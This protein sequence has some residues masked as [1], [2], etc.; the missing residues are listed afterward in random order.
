MS[1]DAMSWRRWTTLPLPL[2]YAIISAACLSAHNA[3]VIGTV[4]TGVS[5]LGAAM[6]SFCIMVIVGYLALCIAVFGV[7]PGLGGF[8][9]YLAAMTAN[10]PLSTGL[11]WTLVNESH[12][13]V[14]VAAP[15]AT[16]AMAAV[17]YLWAHV[18][19]GRARPA[20]RGRCVS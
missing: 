16:V 6:L 15:L 17:N 18:T 11:L 10:F 9:R 4:W 12:L 3:I 8:G 2:R 19:I 13:P 5:V 20:A 7:A 1:F 14:A